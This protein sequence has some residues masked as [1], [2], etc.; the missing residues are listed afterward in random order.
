MLP[1]HATVVA[2]AIVVVLVA[3]VSAVAILVQ[4]KL[5]PVDPAPA[6]TPLPTHLGTRRVQPTT[7]PTDVTRSCII[8]IARCPSFVQKGFSKTKW[9]VDHFVLLF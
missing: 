8:P 1:V 3:L 4:Q 7:G 5:I 6:R 9:T 2:A